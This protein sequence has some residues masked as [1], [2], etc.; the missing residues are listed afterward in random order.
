MSDLRKK[1]AV[2]FG[3][4]SPEHDVSIVTGLQVLSALDPDVYDYIPVY[5]STR[6]Q[7]LIGDSL[8]QR[9]SYIPSVGE[10]GNL[11]P[12][13]LEM[14]N[15][16]KAL[17]VA[18]TRSFLR[19]PQQ[20]TIDFVIPAFHGLYGEDGCVQGLLEMAGVPYSGMRP[21]G[22][23]IFMD[24]VATKKMLASAGIAQLPFKQI[25]K[26]AKG[27][28]VTPDELVRTLGDVKFPQC[29][30]PVHLGSSIGVARVEDWQQLSDVLPL[31]FRYDSS[32]ILEPFVPNLVE[33][34]VAVRRIDGEIKTSAIERPKHGS[35]LLDF[36][37]KYLSGAGAKGKGS[38][39]G[40][41]SEGMLSLTRE[42]NPRISS[43]LDERIRQWA[44]DAFEIVSGTGAP[45]ID[46]LGDAESGEIW[47][48]E[49]NPCPGS[50]AYYLW[51]AAATPVLFSKLIEQL[52]DEGFAV[53]QAMRLPA[54][55]TPDD[56]RL[57]KRRA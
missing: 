17:L 8:D 56:A 28:M 35:E 7:W 5:V 10:I 46:F 40:P 33:Y 44:T 3:G 53:N 32:A 50:F 23:S 27:L 18:Q 19:R 31:I 54:D 6:G 55:P 1:I 30:K 57:F 4:K 9:S 11:T 21:L 24:K 2:L 52:V 16:G 43:A 51:E 25:N 34:N 29:V 26:P 42:I 22:S 47:L 38:A 37:A 20:I 45:R 15:A 48:N 12:V 13:S 36:K 39:K 49:V 41:N 14:G